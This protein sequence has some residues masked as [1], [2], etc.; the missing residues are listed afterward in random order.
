MALCAHCCPPGLWLRRTW[1]RWRSLRRLAAVALTLWLPAAWAGPILTLDEALAAIDGRQ[2]DLAR[3]QHQAEAA[4]ATAVAEGRQPD[5]V[6]SLGLQNLPVTGSDAFR[7]DADD[8]TMTTLGWM[9]MVVPAAR[10][11]AAAERWQA[12]AA[13]AEAERGAT[14][15]RL[16]RDVSLAWL[17]V[18]AAEWLL[19]WQQR[20]QDLLAAERGTAAARQASSDGALELVQLEAERAMTEDQRWQWQRDSRKARAQL[21]RWLGG[22]AE[23]DWPAT[24]PELPPLPKAEVPPAQHPELLAAARSQAVAQADAELARAER[25]PEWNWGVMY[26]LRQ[27]GRADMLSLQLSRP[28]PWDRAHRQDQR[29]AARLAAVAEAGQRQ[30][31]LR[32]DLTAELA[33]TQADWSAATARLHTHEQHL[34]PATQAGLATAEAGYASGRQPLATVWAARRAQL[35][36]EREHELLLIERA[37]AQIRLHYLLTPGEDL[38]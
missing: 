28:L 35:E 3:Y 33:A 29:V 13:L 15:Q 7:P 34:M 31:A 23:Q 6:V 38:P 24:L 8:M 22:R 32:R 12:D 16:R 5:P 4:R 26:G 18:Y 11:Q 17:D 36:V 9:Q 30:E 10:R 25:T 20:W 21:A 27:D 1:P 19:R 14:R 2:P 37:R